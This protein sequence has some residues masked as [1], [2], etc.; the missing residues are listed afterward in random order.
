MAIREFPDNSKE[1][2]TQQTEERK[3]PEVNVKARVQ[4]KSKYKE[5]LVGESATEMKDWI[6]LDVLIP[7]AKKLV[8]DIVANG[9]DML[10]YGTTG[11]TGGT[12]RDS[13]TSRVSYRSYYDEPRREPRRDMRPVGG[14][15]II[16]DSM[17]EGQAIL[18]AAQD[19]IDMY[20]NISMADLLDIAH[21][22][23][24]YTDNNYGWKD[25]RG[26]RITP[27]RGGY[28]LDMPR[29]IPLR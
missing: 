16:V 24:E 29:A 17:Q 8:H 3:L 21:L 2:Q 27:V 4:K 22:P 7:A 20:Q 1:Q 6:F 12:R 9:I 13:N 25:I 11:K 19:V 5:A 23:S 10:L 26:A 18:N 14:A 28:L 15:D